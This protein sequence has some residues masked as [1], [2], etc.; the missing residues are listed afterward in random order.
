MD[1]SINTDLVG[2]LDRVF[3]QD[4]DNQHAN[5]SDLDKI[6][7]LYV[8]YHY[9]GADVTTLEDIDESLCFPSSDAE[10]I[11]FV[12]PSNTSDGEVFDFIFAMDQAYYFDTFKSDL[13]GTLDRMALRLGKVVLHD[14]GAGDVDI[15]A[16]IDQLDSYKIKDMDDSYFVV[17][18]LA[19]IFVT[20]EEKIAM[21]SAISG[22]S[23]ANNPSVSFELLFA[24]DILQEV[25]DVESPKE[26]V[27]NG[28]LKLT[29]QN[30]ALYFGEEK[31]LI[32]LVS[33]TSL[34]QLF[35]KYSTHGLFA[36]NLR[37]FINSKKIDPKI[38]Y[39]I[40]HD[41]DNFPYFNNGIIITC[42]DFAVANGEVQLK[43]FS[44]VNGGQTTNLIGRTP[45]TKDFSVVAKIIK[46]KY[47]NTEDRVTFLS[48][49]AEASNTQK[50]INAKDLIA[51]RVEQRML[52]LQYAGAGMF[53]K[54]KRGE[55]IDK[56]KYPEPWMNASNDEV[57]QM[58]YSYVFQCPG[59]AKNSKSRVLS[60]EK[61]YNQ[62]FGT[63]YDDGFLKSMQY[64][65]IAFNNYQKFIRQSEPWASV[66]GG[67]SRHANYFIDGIIGLIFKAL[68]NEKFREKMIS[69][70]TGDISSTNDDFTFLVRQNDI[71]TITLLNPACFETV[72]KTT[73]FPLFNYFFD[74][75]LVDAYGAY[76]HKSSAGSYGDFCR[77]DRFYYD[78]VVKKT[79]YQLMHD[80]AKII[81]LMSPCFNLDGKTTGQYVAT[82][83]FDDYKP[84]LREELVEFRNAKVKE[85]KDNGYR[86]R[87]ADVLKLDQI[88]AIAT[89]F[90]RSVSLL[91][92]KAD[93]DFDQ[94]NKY[95]EEIIRIVNKYANLSNFQ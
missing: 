87:P 37:F 11:K 45:F 32:T 73:F 85:A 59:S 66:R 69:F 93:M 49:V 90:P 26:Y 89:Y 18:I 52:K 50:P 3:E 38:I 30:S 31:S 8:F 21:Q 42:D 94:A 86:L 28:T 61:T 22:F 34:K 13:K 29:E 17:R 20:A 77:S 65:K 47:S 75:I 46:N 19:N 2:M 36:S 76:L 79:I 14:Y 82:K 78:F 92:S 56:T 51:N 6:A 25:S 40:Q 68:T 23:L 80:S 71:G 53:L 33:A 91:I 35:L 74:F 64:L 48:K 41:P 83:K 24:D 54:V 16:A 95:G 84:G 10:R 15:R 9:N 88:S 55:K 60:N 1:Y 58:L 7:Y 67:L 57:A 5:Y 62:I 72:I 63:S 39:S 81:S 43:N 4:G 12:L 27:P 70:P 44:V